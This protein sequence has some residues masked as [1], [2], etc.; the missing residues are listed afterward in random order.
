M[1]NYKLFI[2][3]VMP[4]FFHPKSLHH[5]KRYLL[6]G[7]FKPYESK[8]CDFICQLHNI[9]EYLKHF[10]LFDMDQVLPYELIIKLVEF[11]VPY[12]CHRQLLVQGLDLTT[13]THNNPI[14]L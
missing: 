11:A 3:G 5:Q 9:V 10:P 14:E 1:T 4:H 8:V 6:W 2:Q 7:L 13:N 12:K